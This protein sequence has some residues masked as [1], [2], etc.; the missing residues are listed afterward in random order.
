MRRRSPNS[1]G[2]TAPSS[3]SRRRGI[4]SAPGPGCTCAHPERS[5]R[6]KS[7]AAGHPA[8]PRTAATWRPGRCHPP[9]AARSSRVPRV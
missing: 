9:P 7:R 6:T 5:E 2:P 8:A 1:T 4:R 3:R